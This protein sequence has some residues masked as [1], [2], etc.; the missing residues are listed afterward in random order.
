V[1]RRS[2]E[3][4]CRA[5][6]DFLAEYL[7]G[8][9]AP[10]VRLAFDAHL[11][12]CAACAGYLRSYAD[13]IHLVKRACGEPDDPVPQEVPEELVRAILAARRAH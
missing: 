9:L 12:D 3:L 7:D 13:T 5:L 6:V 11:A 1:T 8:T 10:D 4:T 2:S